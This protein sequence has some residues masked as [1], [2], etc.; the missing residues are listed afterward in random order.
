MYSITSASFVC[1][2]H[3]LHSSELSLNILSLLSEFMHALLWGKIWPFY[4][5][6]CTDMNT[7]LRRAVRCCPF[8]SYPPPSGNKKQTLEKGS[9]E[10]RD[11]Y[12]EPVEQYAHSPRI[13]GSHCLVFPHIIEALPAGRLNGEQM[14][15]Q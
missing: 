9:C 12:R 3:T 1:V 2:P 4:P 10:R 6:Q 5:P 13:A 14:D 7:N 8:S 15:G 11:F